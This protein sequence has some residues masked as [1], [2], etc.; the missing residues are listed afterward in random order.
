MSENL[1]KLQ[2]ADRLIFLNTYH[3]LK[4]PLTPIIIQLE[5]LKNGEFGRLSRKQKESVSLVFRNIERLDGQIT[6]IL[7]VSRI[8]AGAIK[9]NLRKINL[10]KIIDEKVMIFKP[11][12]KEKGITLTEDVK[13]ASIYA[14]CDEDRIRQVFT[15]LLSN[16]LRF[17]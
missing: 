3:E 10:K 16:A 1:K 9:L 2:Q 8:E 15:N 7:E 6:D 14:L 5:M 12:A 4:T 11:M 13:L 17:A